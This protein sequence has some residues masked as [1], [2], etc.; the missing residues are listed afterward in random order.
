[1]EHNASD[2]RTAAAYGFRHF[3]WIICAVLFFGVT[4]NYMD[5]QILG[6]L[7]TTLQHELGWSEVDYGNIVFAFQTFYAIGMLLGGRF[8][9][10]LGTRF[11]YSV[12]MVFWSLASMA[13]AAVSSVFGFQG[14]RAALGLGE[15]SVFPCSIKAVAEWFPKKERAFAT[16]VF[17]A[18]TNVGA[19]LTPLMIP[20]VTVHFGWRWAFI[21]TGAIGFLWLI[22]WLALYRP[23]EEHPRC[24]PW[25]LAHIRSDPQE[26]AERVTWLRLLPH[27]QTWAFAIGKFLTDPVWWF[28]LFWMPDFLQRKHGLSLTQVALPV[29]AIYIISDVGSVAGGWLSSWMIKRG[30]SINA[31]RKST[32]LLCCL[33]VLPIVLAYYAGSL[34]TA[35]MLIGLAA[36]AHQGYSANLFTL[37]S[38]LFPSRA[39]GTVVGIG[40]M[41]GAIGGMFI[42]KIVGHVLQWTGSYLI[43]FL[44]AAPV[45][46]AA[47]GVIQLLSPRLE[48]A[49]LH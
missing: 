27:R 32:M 29:M 44:V 18:G 15:S 42:A 19:I 24:T 41:G 22:F 13:H 10:W 37:S 20:W 33:C 2:T 6:V 30:V 26:S 5:R 46:F 11:A 23:P 1:M 31:A 8:V 35:V 38:D 48:P 28:Y 3:R 14:A 7:K 49:K 4:K 21:F 16:G 12:A 17:N 9:D 45:Y 36:A 39:V 34:W 47:L 40:G 25:E 43:P